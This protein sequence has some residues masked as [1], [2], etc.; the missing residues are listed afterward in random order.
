VASITLKQQDSQDTPASGDSKI[1]IK[2]DGK[3]YLKD[4]TGAETLV[5]GGAVPGTHAAS[6]KGDGADA[7][8]AATTSVAG[9]L[10]A[11]D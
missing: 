4:A 1:Y 11:A 7:I 9:L 8:A 5:G 2:T 10:P 6:H 3:A